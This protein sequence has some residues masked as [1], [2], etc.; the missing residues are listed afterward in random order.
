MFLTPILKISPVMTIRNITNNQFGNNTTIYQGDIHNYVS[1][2][3]IDQ[4]L[5]DLRLTDPRDD[6]ARIEQIKGGLLRDSYCW[7]LEHTDFRTWLEDPQYWLLWIKGDPGKGKTMLL[8]GI[9]DE[10]KKLARYRLSYFFCQATE[11]R[12]RKATAVLRG[13]IFSLI[14]QQP[15]LISHVRERYN[16]AGKQLFEDENAWIALSKILIAI[17]KDPELGDIICVIDA[18][19]E[20]TEELP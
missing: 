9:I 14:V 4:C 11:P 19:N 2:Q 3:I 6:K 16:H 13:L 17:L 1:H 18:L 8:C 20:C 12:L 15:S 7:I 5:A 10:M